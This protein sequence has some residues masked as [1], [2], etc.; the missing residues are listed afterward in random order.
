LKKED[1]TNKEK[2]QSI[3]YMLEH[4]KMD[5]IIKSIEI[6]FDPDNMNTMI[7]D[8]EAT[9]L[10]YQAFETMMD[11][12]TG[13][14]A[15][16]PTDEQNEKSKWIIRMEMDAEVM[17]E[18]NISMDDIHFAITY[19][20]GDT[21][22]CVYSDYNADNLIFRIRLKT[23]INKKKSN[24]IHSLDQSDEIYYLQNFQ[25]ELLNNLILRGVKKI[26]NI[27]PRK[28][29]DA[30]EEENGT[31]NRKEIWVLDT[32]GTNLL[33]LLT[34]DDF[35]SIRTYTN[36]IQ[37]TFRVLGIEA[38]RQI[39]YNEFTEVIEHDG[40][41]INYH[42]L[43]LLCDRMTV[44]K[45]LVSVFRHG[46]N[47]DDIGPI[48]KASFEETPEQFLKAARHGELD[49]L[50]GISAN[51]MCGQDGYF[52]T[53]AFTI[54]LDVNKTLSL[55]EKQI[56]IINS[57][58]YIEKEF[59][60]ILDP[61]EPCSLNNITLQTNIKNIKPSDLGNDNEYDPFA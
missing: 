34:N 25:N 16:A 55:T 49:N 46:I 7:Q 5:E 33:E 28:I 30:L 6:C 22:S 59:Q 27:I 1:E 9:M 29:S 13:T 3:M 53:S 32:V 35:D 26:S 40:A 18:K 44:N 4:T 54:L 12:C 45:N 10:Q 47:N 8:D 58:E 24:V 41:Y 17:L 38:A 21:I 50:R 51:V 37:E 11:E 48:A 31:Y 42:H 20:Y 2:A 56:D 15:A 60:G 39:I 36:D 61:N 23:F 43:S 52:G 57:E 14:V 19:A